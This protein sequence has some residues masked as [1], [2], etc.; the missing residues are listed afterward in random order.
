M[1]AHNLL[2]GLATA[3]LAIAGTENL[4]PLRNVIYF[5]QYHKTILPGKNVTAGITHVIMAFANSSLFAP[6]TA[7]EYVPFMPVSDVRAMFDNGTQVGIALG[8]WGDTDGFTK[9]A[10]SNETRKA[11]AQN[12]AKMA[13][14]LGFDFVD[15]DW[16]YP[17]GNGADYKQMPNANKTTEITS[18]PLL[19]R[20]I[21]DAIAPK[22]LSIA[23]PALQRDMIA[24]TGYQAPQIF[25]AVDM[26]NL[27]SYDMMNRRDSQT[28]HHSSV[29]G[30]LEAVERY[31]ALGLEP[32]K[33]NLGL[34][35]YAKY[36]QTPDNTTCT[37]PVGCPIVKAEND[38]GSD[39]GTS[40]AMTFE[41]GN[42]Y[43]STPP[44]YLKATSDGTCGAGTAFM[45]AQGTC[46]SQY[47]NCGT[48]PAH[49]G[50]GCQGAYGN[51]SVPDISTS[52]TKALANG[53]LDEEE[54]GMWYW[55]S[56][57]KLF[58]TWD[59]TELMGLKFFE[60]IRPLGLGGVMAW[61]L[62][63]DSAEWRHIRLVS[64]L[65]KEVRVPQSVHRRLPPPPPPHVRRLREG[66]GHKWVH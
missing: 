45:C 33:L 9:G 46:C 13:D 52:F 25:A 34:A 42:V 35:Y 4:A 56:E 64:R 51:C 11:Y 49:C 47:G 28:S 36:F 15:I 39:A 58:W 10:I 32:C 54:L 48:T 37:Q 2:S 66:I 27:M 26:V 24:Y 19:L 60:I 23:V 21:K 63:E 30:S 61:S 43:P 59:T 12:V 29:K 57:A 50:I 1:K 22:Q 44:K 17:G 31:L 7:G 20:A 65:A 62:G 40:G 6:Q 38:D 18:F 5:D 55:D 16:E 53:V 41:K 3:G 14:D 8:G